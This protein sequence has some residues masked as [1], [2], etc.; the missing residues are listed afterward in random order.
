MAIYIQ[1]LTNDRGYYRTV[2]PKEL[3]ESLGLDQAPLLEIM[4]GAAH[5]III[6]EYHGSTETSAGVSGRPVTSHR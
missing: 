1:K 3:V 4:Q 6:K 5:T 2:L